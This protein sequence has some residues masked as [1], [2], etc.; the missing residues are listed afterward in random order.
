M[1]PKVFCRAPYN[2]DMDEASFD[3]GLTC[4]DPSLAQ[5]AFRDET[6]I[7][8]IV[9]RFKLT[10]EVPQILTFPAYQHYEGIFDFQSAM[11]TIRAAQ[12]QFMTLPAKIRSRFHNSPQEFLEFCN[13]E[14]NT[15][16]ALRLGLIKPDDD[17]T[18]AGAGQPKEKHDGTETSASPQT[19]PKN[20]PGNTGT[21]GVQGQGSA[22]QKP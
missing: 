13:D 8:T 19:L 2:Y 17:A 7:N 6:D 12:E 20:Q 10:G 1:K 5:Q 18:L 16:E 15:A 21:Q 14:E 3:T 4:D 22:T 9:D 11:N